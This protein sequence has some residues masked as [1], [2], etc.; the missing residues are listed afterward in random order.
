M[1]A[2]DP[3][4]PALP[5][6]LSYLLLGKT[7]LVS[8]LGSRYLTV[9]RTYE[10]VQVYRT[11]VAADAA[12]DDAFGAAQEAWLEAQ[13]GGSDAT[14][15]VVGSS[16]QHSSQVLDLS[17]FVGG[18]PEG[19]PP[20]RFYLNVDQWDGFPERR[21]RLLERVY[22]PANAVL[23]AG[24][25]HGA[26]ATDFGED[27]G[28]NRAIEL[29]TAAVSSETFRGLLFRTGNGNRAIRESG[30][31]E[32]IVN[33]IDNFMRSA[34]APLRLAE[35]NHHGVLVIDAGEAELRATFNLLAPGIVEQSHYADP[36]VIA[37]QWVVHSFRAT[38]LSGGRTSALIEL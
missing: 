3:E 15:K 6:G 36:S 27:A 22:R 10:L 31:L 34:F 4:D 18:L 1:V 12:H 5:S 17:P 7:T 37:D 24:D 30:L 33:A 19:L 25:I 13:L 20:E 28:G 14:W 23:L 16:V 8:Q 35:S 11:R 21:R 38:K 9:Q 29:T 32:P 26:Y 2:P